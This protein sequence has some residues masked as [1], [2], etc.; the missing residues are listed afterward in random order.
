M[1]NFEI[2]HYNYLNQAKYAVN[3]YYLKYISIYFIEP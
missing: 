3:L 1:C 2:S